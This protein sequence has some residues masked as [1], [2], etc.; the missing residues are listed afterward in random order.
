MS[1]WAPSWRVD[2]I[3][4]IDVVLRRDGGVTPADILDQL[5]TVRFEGTKVGI[6][7]IQDRTDP[8]VRLVGVLSDAESVRGPSGVR[9]HHVREEVGPE[10]SLQSI[11]RI[12]GIRQPCRPVSRVTRLV[13]AHAIAG[14]DPGGPEKIFLMAAILS[15][16]SEQLFRVEATGRRIVQEL[17]RAQPTV[18]SGALRQHGIADDS[19]VGLERSPVDVAA[20]AFWSQ[21]NPVNRWVQ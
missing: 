17:V 6:D 3:I 9:K 16:G 7:G 21:T 8:N 4:V 14:E 15:C 10:Q 19:K 18:V 5:A 1:S 20:S 11:G 2:G 13:A 12:A